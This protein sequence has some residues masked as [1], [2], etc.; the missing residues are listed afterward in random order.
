MGLRLKFNLVLL[1]VFLLGLGGT[2]YLSYSVLNDN[3]RMEVVH[4]AGL[5]M[6]A[7]LSMRGFTA[8]Q[9]SPHLSYQTTAEFLPQSIP[10]FAAGQMMAGLR[11][12]YPDFWYKEAALNPTNP[13]NRPADWETD[14]INAFRN[15]PGLGELVGVRETPTGRSLYLARPF[16]L[17]DPAC[18]V[19]HSVPAAAPASML[20]VY[21]DKNGFGWQLNDVIGMQVVSVPMEVP[22]QNANR[23]FFAFMGLLSAIFVV[24]FLIMNVM[25]TRLLVRP[26]TRMSGAADRISTGDMTIGEFDES[27]K[28][29]MASLAKSFNRMRRSL[30]KAIQLI[31]RQ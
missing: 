31:E 30:E 11:Q 18:L 19:C 24:L 22:I 28:D 2:G 16:V 15:D 20:A 12:K 9:I 13:A 21:G 17:K 29:E 6:E 5:M 26:I 7:A 4:N 8:N 25:M 23:A 1:A 14:V 3:A 27:G 10:A